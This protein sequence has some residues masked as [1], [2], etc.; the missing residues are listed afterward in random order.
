MAQGDDNTQGLGP[1][2]QRAIIARRLAIVCEW[3]RC[4]RVAKSLGLREAEVTQRFVEQ[5]L[6]EGV[7]VSCSTLFSWRR[8][9]LHAGPAALADRRRATGDG[10]DPEPFLI[11]AARAYTGPGLLSIEAC[12]LLATEWAKGN[13]CAVA[14]LWQTKRYIRTQILPRLTAERGW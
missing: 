14:T 10:E 7:K 4:L 3:D 6:A 12:H 11:E 13:G 8:E 9:Y 5:L 2:E 1:A